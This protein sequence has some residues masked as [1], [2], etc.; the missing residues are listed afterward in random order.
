MYAATLHQDV[1]ADEVPDIGG[2][3]EIDNGKGAHVV[4]SKYE[5]K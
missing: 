5:G 2:E 3:V 1:L 4:G